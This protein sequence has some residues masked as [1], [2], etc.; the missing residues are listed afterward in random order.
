[1][2]SLE[3]ELARAKALDVDELAAAIEA[4]G[5]ECTRCGACC[6]GHDGDHT[7]TVFPDDVRE[8]QDATGDPWRDIARP[9]PYGL[10]AGPDGPEGETFEWALQVD[11]CGDCTFYEEAEDG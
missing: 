5:F 4:I 9:M 10:H 3:S 6:R 7:A 8:L 11:D 1:M 2:D